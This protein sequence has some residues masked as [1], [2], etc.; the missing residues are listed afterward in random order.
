MKKIVSV[1]VGFVM[2]FV[3]LF[4]AS[5]EMDSRTF[6][7]ITTN[8]GVNTLS[9]VLRGDLKG[10]SVITPATR[11][12]A[13]AVYT[14]ESTVLSV[15]GLTGGTNT[16]F[17]RAIAQNSSGVAVS[18]NVVDTY[19]LAGLVTVAVTGASTGVN[20]TAVSTQFKK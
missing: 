16:Y 15:S 8:T 7:I 17:P 11:T 13:V 20:T 5:A 19:P 18:T 6:S 4:S 1:I 9:Y 10:V 3:A 14:A 12:N 2:G